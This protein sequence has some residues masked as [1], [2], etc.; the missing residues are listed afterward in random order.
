[1]YDYAIMKLKGN[2][3]LSTAQDKVMPLSIACFKCQIALLENI[4]LEIY[5][6]PYHDSIP[7]YTPHDKE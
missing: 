7:N 3:K 6:Y 4:K 5:G 2:I 1:M